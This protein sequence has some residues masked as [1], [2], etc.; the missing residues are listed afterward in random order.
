MSKTSANSGKTKGYAN[1]IPFKKGQSGNPSGRPK[2]TL[3]DYV[4]KKFT[5]MSDED[6]EK[7]IK[8]LDPEVIWKMGEGNPAQSQEV[9]GEITVKTN[10]IKI[11]HGRDRGTTG[12]E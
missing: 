7:F 2:G 1:L 5:E 6:K 8:H 4:R 10:V 3:K 9:K 12:S 11:L